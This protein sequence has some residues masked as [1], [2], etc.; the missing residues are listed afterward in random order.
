MKS[1]GTQNNL[2]AL[3]GYAQRNMKPPL[4]HACSKKIEYTYSED[5]EGLPQNPRRWKGDITQIRYCG[6]TNTRRHPVRNFP[7]EKRINMYQ[8][9]PWTRRKNC[10]NPRR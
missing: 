3:N 9:G 4:T 7:L 5:I 6:T 10:A 2:W 1:G 8:K